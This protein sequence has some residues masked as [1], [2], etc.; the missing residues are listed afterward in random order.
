[1]APKVHA[2]PCP[3]PD[4][5]PR[6]PLS[7]TAEAGDR[8]RGRPPEPEDDESDSGS[9]N[10]SVDSA[11]GSGRSRSHSA[12]S[13][14]EPVPSE[15][16]QEIGNREQRG[17]PIGAGLT[18]EDVGAL[19]TADPE[20][21]P[22]PA[23]SIAV[24]SGVLRP[25]EAVVVLW[26]AATLVPGGRVA[27]F[28]TAAGPHAALASA[29]VEDC[30]E[31]STNL[32]V[33]SRAKAGPHTVA[34]LDNSG[35]V[36]AS[37]AL[38][39]VEGI[40]DVV[41]RDA[42]LA[43]GRPLCV[44][45]GE[46]RATDLARFEGTVATLE[47]HSGNTRPPAVASRSSI[48][49]LPPH[50]LGAHHQRGTT[51]CPAPQRKGKYTVWY[52]VTDIDTFV[53]TPLGFAPFTVAA[54]IRLITFTVEPTM[55]R[56][57]DHV[58]IRCEVSGHAPNNFLVI[59]DDQGSVIKQITPAY[60]ATGEAGIATFTFPVGDAHGTYTVA[61]CL[62]AGDFLGRP[63]AFTVTPEAPIRQ[64]VATPLLQWPG[65]SVR[66][67]WDTD[68]VL[69][70]DAI[71]LLDAEQ[72]ILKIWPLP[73]G[74]RQLHKDIAA[75]ASGLGR[76]TVRYVS[77]QKG[78]VAAETF[79]DVVEPP[80]LRPGTVRVHVVVNHVQLR[81]LVHEGHS[82]VVAQ[83]GLAY[84]LVLHSTAP[85][86]VLA[87]ITIDGK[88]MWKWEAIRP[89]QS[90]HVPG[91]RESATVLRPMV[92]AEPQSMAT[93]PL[94][95][96]RNSDVGCI[97]VDIFP[98]TE[99][100]MDVDLSDVDD[101]VDIDGSCAE[102]ASAGPDREKKIEITTAFGQISRVDCALTDQFKYL[103]AATSH[104][105]CTLKTDYRSKDFMQIRQLIPTIYTWLAF[106]RARVPRAL[107]S[108]VLQTPHV[109]SPGRDAWCPLL[110]AAPRVPKGTSL[111][112]LLAVPSGVP[113]C[114]VIRENARLRARADRLEA[115]TETFPLPQA[116]AIAVFGDRSVDIC[117]WMVREIRNR[118]DR[119]G[120]HLVLLGVP[121]TALPALTQQLQRASAI[122]TAALK[123]A[124][125]PGG[126]VAAAR[127]EGLALSPA[128]SLLLLAAV[129][130]HLCVPVTLYTPQGA[131]VFGNE[132]ALDV[133]YALAFS[134]TAGV[135]EFVRLT[136][137]ALLAERLRQLS[138]WDGS[139]AFRVVPVHG[140][141]PRKFHWKDRPAAE[142]FVVIDSDDEE[143]AG[144]DL[145]LPP[146]TAHDDGDDNEP[147]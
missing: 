3:G 42:S 106:Y 59:T 90:V 9:D 61:Y 57:R 83:P 96:E 26:S 114:T 95:D 60:E 35:S 142:E 116:L 91:F 135:G 11:H 108:R 144:D 82:Y 101:V 131:I 27:L 63:V 16:H 77:G 51:V 30:P 46:Q 23:H 92:F 4:A 80:S 72:R 14:V 143:A 8:P 94:R 15:M 70:G 21:Y 49:V 104:P 120:R 136:N 29:E 119:Y 118:G 133:G 66:V 53:R 132:T 71:Q 62:A 113:E 86:P 74:N 102:L 88:E 25:G 24:A 7:T 145:S 93:L 48:P 52:V 64:L 98:A 32:M 97:V 40:L 84:G 22:P 117:G 75:P 112:R 141:S 47:I 31:G 124:R 20:Q 18:A 76:Y 79:F 147:T 54:D 5:P 38:K 39:V 12:S 78:T 128:A 139:A 65:G 41:V 130:L 134:P 44:A 55:V 122:H 137:S 105:V 58:T 10:D 73:K 13:S 50:P 111:A 103:Q 69:A 68:T 81:Q 140:A 43:A 56:P 110:P 37:A 87:R 138:A 1:V 17:H 146:M 67:L 45:W 19:D 6:V 126:E 99:H 127:L 36:L 28:P 33:P 109:P 2:P 123:A 34:L 121:S 100:A 129:A 115:D 125:R 89:M 107:Q 85:F